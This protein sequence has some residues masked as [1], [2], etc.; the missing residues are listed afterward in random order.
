MNIGCSDIGKQLVVGQKDKYGYNLER[1]ESCPD[2]EA[3]S[4]RDLEA[5]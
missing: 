3:V 5:V 4:Q 2:T 1:V